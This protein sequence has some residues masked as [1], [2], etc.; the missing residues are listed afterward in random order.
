MAYANAFA[1]KIGSHGRADAIEWLQDTLRPS[2]C[3]H[4][5]FALKDAE[6]PKEA[7]D[8]VLELILRPHR[9]APVP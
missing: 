6:Y 9:K 5:Y 2:A 3:P 4:G 7:R 8:A 1:V